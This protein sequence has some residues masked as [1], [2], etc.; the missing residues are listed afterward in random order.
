MRKVHAEE[1]VCPS[2]NFRANS[3]NGQDKNLILFG[4]RNTEREKRVAH[5]LLISTT[6]ENT[7]NFLSLL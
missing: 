3:W 5:R 4:L 1:F 6:I 2:S 7:F